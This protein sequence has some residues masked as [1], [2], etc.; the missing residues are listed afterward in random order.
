MKFHHAN[1]GAKSLAFVMFNAGSRA[2]G[3]LSTDK[4]ILG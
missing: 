2:Y 1:S 4:A 3:D